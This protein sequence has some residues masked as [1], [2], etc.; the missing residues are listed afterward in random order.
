MP[1][2]S[3][4]WEF[5][6]LDEEFFSA[7]CR[8]TITNPESTLERVLENVC[9]GIDAAQPLAGLIPEGAFPARGLI[10]ALCHLVKL[11]TVSR[12]VAYV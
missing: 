2:S 7:L 8:W 1:P 3:P 12:L 11:G 9:I 5:W 10:D 6:T 4:P